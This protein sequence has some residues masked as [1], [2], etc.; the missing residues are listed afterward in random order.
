[1]G[2]CTAV[3]RVSLRAKRSNLILSF[4]RKQE[5]SSGFPLFPFDLFSLDYPYAAEYT[6]T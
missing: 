5:S 3:P 1:L 6:F 2:L 4:P